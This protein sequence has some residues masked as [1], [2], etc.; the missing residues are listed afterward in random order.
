M[1]LSTNA[2]KQ[3][4]M[5]T[6][7]FCNVNALKTNRRFGLPMSNLEDGQKLLS[8]ILALLPIGNVLRDKYVKC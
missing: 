7:P 8:N 1:T 3:K 2:A 5:D 4:T 6:A